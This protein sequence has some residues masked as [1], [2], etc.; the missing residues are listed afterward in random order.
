MKILVTAKYVSGSAYEG[1]SSRFYKTVIDTLLSMG[2]NV[3]VTTNPCEYVHLGF[4]LI[5]C[6]HGEKLSSI[7]NN[8]APKVC[9]S[10]GIIEEEKMQSGANRYISV[11][12]EVQLFNRERGFESEVIPQPITIR[13]QTRP[14]NELKNILII[15]R[16]PMIYDPFEFL[17]EKYNVMESDIDKPIEDQIAQADL[18]IT[19]GRGALEAMAQGKPVLVADNRE[20]IGA[21][22][23]GYVN[24]DNIAEIAKNNFSGRRFNIPITRE[25]IES[26]L[27]KYNPDDSDFLYNYVKENHGADQIVGRYLKETQIH[28][29]MPLW[30]KENKGNLTAAYRP[31]RV[32]WHP[33]M[34]RDEVVEFSEPWIFPVVIPMYSKE[35]KV[36]HPGTFKRNWFI[37]NRQIVDDDYYVCAD[38][39]DMY[40]PNV[41]SEI[42]TINDDIIIISMKRGHKIP[43][44]AV[45]PRRYPIDTLYASP[46]YVAIAGISGQQSFV[47]GKIFRKHLFNENSGT[48]DGE[49]AMHH[50]ESGEQIVYRPD[51]FALFNYYEKGRW[52]KGLQVS[53]GVM[54]N[55]PLRLDMVLKQSQI[56]RSAYTNFHFI[57][58]PESATKGL[59]YL[60]D[61]IDAEG[62]DV[63][64]LVHQDMYFRNGWIEK[65]K[66]KLAELP[67]SWVVAGIIGKDMDGLICG[68]FHD[69]RIPMDFDTSHVHTFPQAACCFDE[70]VIMVNMASKYR[71]DEKFTGFDL[72][73]TL[74]VLQAWEMGGTAWVIDAFAEH[75]CMRKFSWS[76][77]DLFVENY[78][79]L[80][81]KYKGIRVDSTALGLPPDGEVRFETSAAPD[82]KAA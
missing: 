13:K 34:F 3:T 52:E 27:A 53:F 77:D 69:M 62:S 2:H 15:R 76:P 55:D 18:C 70:C 32:C 16:Y 31:M 57:Q 29:I 49:M 74:C 43:R 44:E 5:I 71:F 78:K 60:L 50:K 82:E 48:W 30:R 37:K 22:G 46:D 33:I 80:Y 8:P 65:V 24:K 19:L 47:K 14:K 12:Q 17:S 68:Q 59:N 28:L 38:D 40:E 1:G 54:V 4:D 66:I 61:K 42:K 21:K 45:H 10:H 9:I 72:Y 63:A 73:G 51:L 81:D 11:S 26:E 23:D 39:D 36:A 6:S 67:D 41:M 64:I 25:W 20:Y 7:K 35:C 79:R 58:N 75:Y 56:P